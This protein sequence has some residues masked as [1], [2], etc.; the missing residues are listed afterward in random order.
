MPLVTLLSSENLWEVTFQV[1]SDQA[2]AWGGPHQ[3]HLA[4]TFNGWE[5]AVD[6]FDDADYC[7]KIKAE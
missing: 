3:I 6:A 5:E 7:D 1:D 2:A 4:G